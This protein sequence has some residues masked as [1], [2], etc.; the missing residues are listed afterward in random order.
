MHMDPHEFT[1]LEKVEPPE[2]VPEA[3]TSSQ[4]PPAGLLF[5]FFLCGNQ[6]FS[7]LGVLLCAFFF[8]W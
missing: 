8:G 6:E 7:G 3:S 4:S 2:G 1:E 5:L